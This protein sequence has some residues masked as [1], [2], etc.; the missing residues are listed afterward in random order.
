MC[1]SIC[2]CVLYV[3][4][5]VV[6]P[7]LYV[8]AHFCISLSI[9]VCLCPF[10]C[11]CVFLSVSIGV[12]YV[13]VSLS[14]CPLVYCMCVS[15]SLCVH[16]CP[17]VYSCLSPCVSVYSFP[18]FILLPLFSPLLRRSVNSLPKEVR[19]PRYTY[20]NHNPFYFKKILCN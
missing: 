11:V 16:L 14:L 8:F 15:C 13:C 20:S 7:F 12:L 6:C 3:I 17:S 4:G 5:E 1:L 2:V 9:C 18:P 10:V 19:V